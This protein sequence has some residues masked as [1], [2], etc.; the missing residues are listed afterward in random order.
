MDARQAHI[1]NHARMIDSINLVLF[2]ANWSLTKIFMEGL[3]APYVI[4]WW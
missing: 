4:N 3:S 2:D 1:I